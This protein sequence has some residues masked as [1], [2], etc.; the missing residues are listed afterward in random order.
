MGKATLFCRIEL[1]ADPI[2]FSVILKLCF[3]KFIFL[4]VKYKLCPRSDMI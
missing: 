2:V 4:S 3:A 1:G